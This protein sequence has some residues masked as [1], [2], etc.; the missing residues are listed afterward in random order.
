M[1]AV[2]A[3]APGKINWTLE[4]LGKRSDGYHELRTVMQTISLCDT[5]TVSEAAESRLEVRG[6]S[7]DSHDMRDNENLAFRAYKRWLQR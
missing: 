4:V 1:R 2:R 7:S 3:W 6:R 5:V